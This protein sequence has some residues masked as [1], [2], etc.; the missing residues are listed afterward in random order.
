LSSADVGVSLHAWVFSDD[1]TVGTGSSTG[2]VRATF[3]ATY[4]V[5][6]GAPKEGE[7]TQKKQKMANMDTSIAAI[8]LFQRKKLALRQR[9]QQ[10]GMFYPEGMWGMCW[11]AIN[12]LG[13]NPLF[14]DLVQKD[15]LDNVFGLCLNPAGGGKMVL[16]GRGAWVTQP[17]KIIWT[18][19]VQQQFYNVRWL[20]VRIGGKS[21]G[22]PQRVYNEKDAIV[23]SGTV[24]PTLPQP[25][26]EKFKSTLLEQCTHTH[27][28]G[29]CDVPTNETVLDG[30]CYKLSASE[31]AAYPTVDFVLAGHGTQH[32]D[33]ILPYKPTSFMQKQYFCQN[34]GEVAMGIDKDPQFSILGAEIMQAYTTV[35]DRTNMRIGFSPQLCY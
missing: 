24:M 11:R 19:I 17:Q 18:P 32:S 16:G 35:F 21:I 14:D 13:T 34:E 26:W 7:A 25:A 30:V 31:I 5:S 6:F 28:K 15:N 4:N 10:L 1:V 3:G 29:L 2:R 12:S 33:A 22:V 8:P 23:D 27:L 20:D 9:A